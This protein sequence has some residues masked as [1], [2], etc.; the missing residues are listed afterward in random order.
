MD[1]S[2]IQEICNIFLSGVDVEKTAV[3]TIIVPKDMAVHDL[4]RLQNG[5]YRFRG[6]MKTNSITS[7]VRYV[8]KTGEHEKVALQSFVSKNDM[9]A[10]TLFNM[11]TVEDPGHCDFGARLSLVKTALYQVALNANGESYDQQSLAEWLEDWRDVINVYTNGAMETP[12]DIR[13][14]ITSVRKVTIKSET[15]SEHEKQDFEA[16]KNTMD[17]VSAKTEH[18]PSIIVFRCTPFEGLQERNF[19][20]RVSMIARHDKPLF[21]LR[22]I[23]HEEAQEEMATEFQTLLE[24]DLNGD[25]YVGTFN[26]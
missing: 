19:H 7:F 12:T 22:L 2:A 25:V 24:K 18:M 14:V 8:T 15:T 6:I 23:K 1:K 11:G 26:P 16:R 5:R 3:P 13:K 10:T 21:R 4:E 17:E 20:F 9:T